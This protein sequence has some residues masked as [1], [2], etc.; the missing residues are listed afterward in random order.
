MLKYGL[1]LAL[2]FSSSVQANE[3]CINEHFESRVG[4]S[5]SYNLTVSN[6]TAQGVRRL[7]KRESGEFLFRQSAKI[8]IASIEESSLFTVS[9]GNVM[10]QRYEREQ[11]GLG[12][13]RTRIDYS[14]NVAVV[15][16]K[17]KESRYELPARFQDP[18]TS[19]LALQAYLNCG[20]ASPIELNVAGAKGYQKY[21]YSRVS[22][23][24]STET[25]KGLPLEYWERNKNGVKEV[26]GFIPD[27]NYLLASFVQ[28]KEGEINRLELVSLPQ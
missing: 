5:L 16:R 6:M 8:L 17:K 1:A 4:E 21:T 25:F 18:Q 11:K 20:A 23:A 19:V 24:Q 12:A 13:K 15:V 2:V 22:T 3:A 7:E 26:F 28:D 14:S 27:K 10:P 9:T